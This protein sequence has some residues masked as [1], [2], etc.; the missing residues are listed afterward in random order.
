MIISA[1][2]RRKDIGELYIYQLYLPHLSTAV[3]STNKNFPLYK[4]TVRY[5]LKSPIF[6]LSGIRESGN[7]DTFHVLLFMSSIRS[8]IHKD[9]CY[10]ES[11]ETS[12][13]RW[14]NHKS[15]AKLK[16]SDS[17]SAIFKSSRLKRFSVKHFFLGERPGGNLGTILKGLSV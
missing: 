5:V 15:D 8:K 10:D 4:Q 1:D 9:A 2:R 11:T 13:L 16:S 7:G 12:K 14:A 3:L 17:I 6:H